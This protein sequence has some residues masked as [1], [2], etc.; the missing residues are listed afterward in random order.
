MAKKLYL[1]IITPEKQVLEKEAE[2]VVMP[3]FEGEMGV[4]A[5]HTPCIIQLKE[6]ILRYTDGHDA[7]AFAVSGGFAEMYKDRILIFAETAEL[8]EEVNI[9]RAR[10]ALQKAKEAVVSG[11]RDMDISSAQASIRRAAAR[12]HA[13]DM[14]RA[15]GRLRKK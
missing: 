8:A 6:G 15:G 7:G 13:A 12:I 3:A 4:L 5:G 9:E 10:Q 11:G 1:Q 14:K 2:F